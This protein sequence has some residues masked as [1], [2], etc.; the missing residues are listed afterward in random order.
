MI[1]AHIAGVPVEETLPA[2]IP[3]GVLGV[4]LASVHIRRGAKR[5]SAR[6]R[7]GPTAQAGD[8]QR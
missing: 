5:L 4:S 8:G 3:V 2:V 7:S 1:V 6:R